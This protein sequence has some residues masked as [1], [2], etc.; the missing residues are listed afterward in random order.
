MYV[1]VFPLPFVGYLLTSFPVCHS[2]AKAHDQNI[3]YVTMAHTMPKLTDEEI[4]A[5][6]KR[7]HA[8]RMDALEGPGTAVN[9]SPEG[10]INEVNNH[11]EK[12][13]P[14]A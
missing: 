3:S 14:S 4:E 9:P 1:P 11:P 8:E 12:T 5:E 2:F 6:G 10:T 13:K 7:L